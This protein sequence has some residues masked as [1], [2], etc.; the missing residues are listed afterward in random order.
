[1][2]EIKDLDFYYGNIRVLNKVSLCIPKGKIVSILGANGAGKTTLLKSVT[3]LVKI[4][5]G[6]LIFEGKEITNIPGQEIVKKGICQVLEG[7]QVFTG[8]TTLDNLK[9]GAYIRYHNEKS[10]EIEKD[11]DFV[12]GIFPRLKE[13]SNQLAGTLSGGEQQMLA[14]GRALMIRPKL[15]LLDEPSLGLAPMVVREILNVVVRLRDEGVTI[16]IVEQRAKLAL[17][18]SDYGYVL[19]LGRMVL[20][21]TASNLLENARVRQAYLG[22]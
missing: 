4:S 17:E 15:L 13:R 6:H 18:T 1:M 8:L 5:S 19:E 3:G 20:E 7:R 16:V 21:D 12:Y 10:K 14:I 11:I 9:L 22:G 2:L